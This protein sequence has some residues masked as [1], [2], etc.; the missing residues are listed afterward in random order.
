MKRG[1]IW[2]KMTPEAKPR[3][4]LILTRDEAIPLLNRVI[5]VPLTGTARGIPTEVT[6]GTEDGLR[7]ESVISVDNVTSTAKSQLIEHITQLSPAKLH[8]V[9]RALSLATGCEI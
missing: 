3:P 2:W 9:C 6:V 1:E 7:R 5:T 8:A 4:H